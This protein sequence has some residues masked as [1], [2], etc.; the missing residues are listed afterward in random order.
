MPSIASC[1]R[2]PARRSD[3]REDWHSTDI[4]WACNG[5]WSAAAEGFRS[6][7]PFHVRSLN[8]FD[9]CRDRA[10]CNHNGWREWRIAPLVLIARGI[11]AAANAATMAIIEHRLRAGE[12]RRHNCEWRCQCMSRFGAAESCKQCA[13]ACVDRNRARYCVCVCASCLYM[14][15]ARVALAERHGSCTCAADMA[16]CS[17]LMLKP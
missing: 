6:G 15:L 13:P 11:C 17:R 12:T 5:L 1:W 9:E 16:A 2:T 7:A 8:G 14:M 10:V 4:E 3:A